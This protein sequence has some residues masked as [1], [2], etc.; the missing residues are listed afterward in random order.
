MPLQIRKSVADMVAE[1]MSQI[2]TITVEQALALHERH[3]VA[4][5]DLRDPRE[6]SGRICSRVPT[7]RCCA[8]RQGLVRTS[9]S[10]WSSGSAHTW[11]KY[12]NVVA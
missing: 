3:D 9:C 12:W 6:L 4:F 8:P 10:G 11:A 2:E 5:V 1:A 7:R